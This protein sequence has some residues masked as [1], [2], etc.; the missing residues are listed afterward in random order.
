VS[1]LELKVPAP[2]GALA[3]PDAFRSLCIYSF[4][5]NEPPGQRNMPAEYARQQRALLPPDRF[6]HMGLWLNKSLEGW[7]QAIIRDTWVVY[8]NFATTI[9]PGMFNC[10]LI[11]AGMAG[12]A[13]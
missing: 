3:D 9:L 1:G 5:Y 13:S 10:Y 8:L 12:L 4:N 2:K 11:I 7:T 6:A